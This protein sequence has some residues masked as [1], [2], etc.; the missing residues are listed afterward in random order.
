MTNL[1]I[2]A[3]EVPY[4]LSLSPK[5]R[6]LSAVPSAGTAYP[7]I[8]FLR[9]LALLTLAVVA[10]LMSW[11]II[12]GSASRAAIFFT[13]SSG[14]AAGT[15]LEIL[16]SCG[17]VCGTS[18]GARVSGISCKLEGWSARSSL[19]PV[20]ATAG[21]SERLRNV[22]ARFL[23]LSSSSYHHISLFIHTCRKFPSLTTERALGVV[24]IY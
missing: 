22:C 8:L 1:S 12:D 13:V 23:I 19:I 5:T 16:S 20:F 3:G 24:I 6:D 9:L 15:V 18:P 7:K 14:T 10:L 4:I 17:P 11:P 2:Y 21:S